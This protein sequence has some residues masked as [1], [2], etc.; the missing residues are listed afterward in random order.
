MTPR[1]FLSPSV[2]VVLTIQGLI[3]YSALQSRLEKH[4]GQNQGHVEGKDLMGEVKGIHNVLVR[5]S[6]RQELSGKQ[7]PDHQSSL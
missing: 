1:T 7:G 4:R 2:N 6:R 5:N 3:Y